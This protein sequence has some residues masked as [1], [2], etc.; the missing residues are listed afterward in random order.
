MTKAPMHALLDRRTLCI[1]GGQALFATGLTGPALA[2]ARTGT[3]TAADIVSALSGLGSA[4]LVAGRAD[5]AVTGVAL[6]TDPTLAALRRA[7]ASG[8]SLILSP[9]TPYYGRSADPS[10]AA[11][12]FAALTESALR[13][14]RDSP[15]LEAKRVFVDQHDLAIFRLTPNNESRKDASVEAFAARLGW[16]RYRVPGEHPIYR[17]PAM[18]LAALV[19][20]AQARLAASGGLRF[21]G[22]PAMR[23]GSVLLVPGTSEVVSTIH[24][25]ARAD[26][27]LTGDMRE[28][29]VVEYVHDSAEAGYP[30]ALVSTGRILS[31]QPFVERCAL[32][33]DH[34]FPNLP[35]HSFLTADPFWR[36]QA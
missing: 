32:A 21:I 6:I 36:V 10:A 28:W 15:A 9:E 23:L 16:T 33:V 17:P 12:P 31:E 8:C 4:E 24:G 27:L 2:Q 29:E 26:A 3:P 13:A 34:A 18:T 30:K 20:L 11:G 14:L 35:L 5:A 19:K 25:L 1:A 7:V 22:D